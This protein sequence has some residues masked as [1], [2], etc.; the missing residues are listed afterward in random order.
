MSSSVSNR[1]S[2]DRYNNN[3][4]LNELIE[5]QNTSH[6]DD[7]Q[8]KWYDN[9]ILQTPVSWRA[10]ETTSSIYDSLWIGFVMITLLPI[11]LI[12]FILFLLLWILPGFGW[13]YE[14]YAEARDR[15]KYYPPMDEMKPWGPDNKLM[16]V[17]H[18]RAPE[19]TFPPIIY[20]SGMGI[21]MY[22]VK[23]LLLKYIEHIGE[24]IEII[25]FDSPGYGAS[26]PP[27]DWNAENIQSELLLLRKVIEMSKLRKPFILMGGS[28]G[29]LMAHLYRLTY[30]EDVA[31]VILHDP[32]PPT[33]FDRECPMAKDLNWACSIFRIMACI[34]PWGLLRPLSYLIPHFVS[35][36]TGDMSRLLVPDYMALLMTQP[37]LQKLARQLDYWHSIADYK[38]K[39]QNDEIVHRNIPLLVITALHW[40][41]KRPHSGLTREEIRQWWY[42]NEQCFLRSSDNAGFIPRK[43][44]THIQCVF[45]MEL[46]ANAT[47]VILTQIHNNTTR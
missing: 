44:Y 36:K 37:M 25:S 4:D 33:L 34:A 1:K 18:F 2:L 31:G 6:S 32:T 47:R 27:N 22:V 35:D 26:E 19:S 7:H 28:L 21:N 16:H 8:Y 13:F 3:D 43:D 24:P 14:R 46:A 20:L 41:Q 40:T 23:T 29:G 12:T 15:R 11:I 5:G 9:P 17:V 42:D 45:D 39:F 38:S 10:E 30:P